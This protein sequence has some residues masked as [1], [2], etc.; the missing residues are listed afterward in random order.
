M[1]C[2][3]FEDSDKLTWLNC[4]GSMVGAPFAAVI[5]DRFGRK[6]G[7]FTG[8]IVIIVGMIVISSSMTVPQLVVGRFILGCGIA[9]MTVAAPAYAIEIA[10]PHWRGRFAGRCFN[11]VTNIRF[12]SNFVAT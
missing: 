5:S 3:I 12:V 2:S 8:A 7:M 9:I 11:F 6:K 10:P 1:S 4:S